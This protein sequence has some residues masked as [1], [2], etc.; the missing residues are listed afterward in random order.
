[1][2]VELFEG[3][4]GQVRD[5]KVSCPVCGSGMMF[6]ASFAW[7]PKPSKSMNSRYWLPGLGFADVERRL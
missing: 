5:L 4:L 7:M 3:D 1:M 6:G 2:Q